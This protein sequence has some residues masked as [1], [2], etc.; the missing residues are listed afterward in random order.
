MRLTRD[1]VKL[2]VIAKKEREK[3]KTLKN[4]CLAV[5]NSRAGEIPAEKLTTCKG[6]IFNCYT[7]HSNTENEVKKL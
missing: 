4:S 7:S 3:K 6:S 2:L 5:K 1:G